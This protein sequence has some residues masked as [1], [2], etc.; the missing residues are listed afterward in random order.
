LSYGNHAGTAKPLR[1]GKGTSWEGGTRVPC[2]MR[3]PGKIPA[4]TDT[5]DMLMTIDLL[6]TIAGRTG[7]AL[8]TNR[9]DGLDVWPLISRQPGAKNPHDAY[10]FYYHVNE[11]QAVTT[12]DGRWKLMLPQT[13]R[14]LRGKPVGRDGVP[15]AYAQENV[16][17]PE[18]YDLVND[19]GETTDVAAS[20]PEIVK[21]L[22]AAAEQ[23]RADLGD[24]QTDRPGPGRREPG[25]LKAGG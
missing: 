4:G 3:W 10:W 7:A 2:I 13:Y 6:P 5:M 18:L 17:K 25:R 19:I 20:H 8:S 9:I 12:G 11:L 15:A 24:R 16:L 1:E 22:E 14:T 21:Q 23:A